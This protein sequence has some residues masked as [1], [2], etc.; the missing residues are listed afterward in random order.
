MASAQMQSTPKSTFF[1]FFISAAKSA[2]YNAF[3]RVTDTLRGWFRE[4]LRRRKCTSVD[5]ERLTSIANST[6]SRLLN[7][8]TAK[9]NPETIEALCAWAD[10]TQ[11]DL[12]AISRG[13]YP[14]AK[15]TPMLMREPG[16]DDDVTAELKERFDLISAWEPVK[17]K[18]VAEMLRIWTKHMDQDP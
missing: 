2:I 3:V 12:L 9:L 8:R 18:Q 16:P 11:E 5:L 10:I 1:H 17:Q 4:E 14:K 15:S 6:W 13:E 7:G